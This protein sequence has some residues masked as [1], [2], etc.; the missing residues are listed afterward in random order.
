MDFSDV[1]K[2]MLA[3]K[4]QEIPHIFSNLVCDYK[5]FSMG[6]GLTE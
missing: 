4:R 2:K 6:N 5:F 3:N 1:I